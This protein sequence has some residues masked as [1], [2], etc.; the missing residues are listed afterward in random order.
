MNGRLWVND[1]DCLVARPEI[2]GR[3][4]WAAHLERYGGLRFSSDRLAVLDERGRELTRRFLVGQGR[5]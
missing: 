2:N 3:E 4:A 1:P 5:L